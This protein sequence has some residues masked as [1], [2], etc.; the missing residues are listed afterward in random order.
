VYSKGLNRLQ[1]R[2]CLSWLF[3]AG[4]I[5]GRSSQDIRLGTT[6]KLRECLA[7]CER[8]KGDAADKTKE[9]TL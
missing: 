2:L 6:I 9:V 5:M 1:L 3:A 8:K 7:F 4:L